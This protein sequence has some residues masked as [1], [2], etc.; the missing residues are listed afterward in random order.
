MISLF[1]V[2]QK[3]VVTSRESA[4]SL[5]PTIAA[6]AASHDQ[7]IIFDFEGIQGVT[8]SVVDEILLILD[9]VL[10]PEYPVDPGVEFRKVPM[11][12]SRKYDAV[13][14]AHK[15]LF[16]QDGRGS[17]VLHDAREAAQLP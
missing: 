1:D 7:P 17:W 14:N 16:T 4:R 8:P 15:L 6:A 2:L 3:R 13:A 10:P 5:R 9:A 11:E 12:L